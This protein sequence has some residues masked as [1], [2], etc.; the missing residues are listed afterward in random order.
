MP[1]FTKVALADIKKHKK[2]GKK[3]VLKK[4]ARLLNEIKENPS[5]GARSR[6]CLLLEVF[7]SLNDSSKFEGR[8]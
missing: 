6:W 5:Q 8:E 4:I 7:L 3:A 1:A 2:A